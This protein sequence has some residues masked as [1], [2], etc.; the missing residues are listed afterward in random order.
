MRELKRCPFCGGDNVGVWHDRKI[1]LTILQETYEVRCYDCHFGLAQ[2]K[3]EEE[4]I[5]DW[6]TRKPIEKVLERLENNSFWTEPTYDM[7][8]YSNDDELEVIRL[9]KAIEIINEEVG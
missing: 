4:A 3:T 9:D 1:G 2:V 6:N 8:G 7:D 5:E